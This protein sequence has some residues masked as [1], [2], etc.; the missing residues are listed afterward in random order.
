MSQVCRCDLKCIDLD[1][2]E[3]FPER[4]DQGLYNGD[5]DTDTVI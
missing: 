3:S 2:M 4:C 5:I 1:L